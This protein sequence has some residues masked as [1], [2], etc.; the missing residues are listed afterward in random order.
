[1]DTQAPDPPPNP[2]LAFLIRLY[3]YLLVLLVAYVFSAGP[4]YWT[5]YEAYH[6][7]G[8]PFIARLYLPL[9][10]ASEYEPIGDFMRWYVGLWIF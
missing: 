7:D 5:V 8:D 4:M 9:V 10:W 3:C 6:L 1:M 2:F